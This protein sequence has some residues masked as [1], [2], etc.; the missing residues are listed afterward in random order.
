MAVATG[1]ALAGAAAANL[2]GGLIGQQQAAGDRDRAIGATQDYYNQLA[3]LTPPDIEK[4]KLAL[5]GYQSAG[6]LTPQTESALTLASRDPLQDINL[7]PRLK[8]A[9]IQQL[10]ALQKLGDTGMSPEDQAML[11]QIRRQTESDNQ[12]RMKSLLENQQARGVASGEGALAAQLLGT[13]SSAN[14]QSA[15]AD[16][17]AAMAFRRALDAKSGAANLAGAMESTDYGR[18]AALAQALS[19]RENVNVNIQNASQQRNIDRF[20]QAQQANLANQQQIMAQNVNLRN[21]QQRFNKG[22]SQQEYDNQLK[23]LGLAGG[24]SRDMS[25]AYG[26]RGAA[27]AGMWGGIGSGIGQAFMGAGM[28]GQKTSAGTPGIETAQIEPIYPQTNDQARG[29]VPF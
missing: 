1:T 25:G 12:S 4:M 18:Q 5:E 29:K 14:R 24:A 28:A 15:E 16:Q 10:E 7:D 8:Q 3:R 6:Q 20:N 2:V 23:K 21:E 9:Q 17:M 27:T 26:Q 13:Q 19:G 11:N 22:L